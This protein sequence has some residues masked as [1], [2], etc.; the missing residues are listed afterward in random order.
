MIDP[1]SEILTAFY[2]AL[3]GNLSY[4]SAAWSVY[5]SVPRESDERDKF[6][7]LEELS[8]SDAATKDQKMW[9]CML[10]IEVVGEIS[11][12][13]VSM[14]PVDAIASQIL[15]ALYKVNLSMTSFSMT[16][17]P[18]FEDVSGH[19]DIVGS[20]ILARKAIRCRFGVQEKSVAGINAGESGGTDWMDTDSDG[21][22]NLWS[23]TGSGSISIVQGNGFTGNALK[24]VL[25]ADG[26]KL[27]IT[28]D[29]NG[30]TVLT[31]GRT[32]QVSCK[33]RMQTG[34]AGTMRIRCIGG[35][36]K[37]FIFVG[38]NTGN[39]SNSQTATLTG[40][41][42]TGLE[43]YQDSWTEDEEGSWIEIDE[44]TITDIT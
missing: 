3:N 16:V 36:V 34:A 33:Y 2:D 27:R 23:A 5:T 21:T 29:A 9:D 20:G 38:N 14:K 39:A 12:G 35:S 31:A 37:G 30:D 26:D 28:V 1:S 13:R 11:I 41:D 18:W 6:V 19:K 44:L 7:V 4:N 42:G 32:Y 8:V 10:T 15:N 40:V 25:N 24:F 17:L 22:P 43:F